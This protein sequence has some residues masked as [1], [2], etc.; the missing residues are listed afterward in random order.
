MTKVSQL[1]R[2]ALLLGLPVSAAGLESG[3]Q[4]DHYSLMIDGKRLLSFGGEMHP[5]RIPV[6]ELW[7]DIL[8]K[9][10]ASGMNTMSFYTHW[11]FHAPTADS[12]DFTSGAH[13]LTPLFE[14]AKAVGVYLHM[15]PGPYINAE[16]SAGGVPLWITT[17]AYGSLRNTDETYT[18]AW[19]PYYRAIAE[20]AAPYQVTRNG[21]LVLFQVENEFPNQWINA[22]AKT[23]DEVP[24]G[25]MKL[26]EANA[27][28]SGIDI[29]LTHNMPSTTGKSWSK[30]YDT[31]GA[32]GDVDIYGLDSYVSPIYKRLISL[33][34]LIR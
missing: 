2:C 1:I 26:L 6:P 18:A 19:T 12:L 4:W 31:V 5:W 29:A 25:Y 21:T 16:T 34:S 24:I 13:N 28:E 33:Q 7:E 9:V 23:P 17:G 10:K 20:A 32:G 3:I 22:T 11:G 30:D 8:E 14:Q 15:R 27:R